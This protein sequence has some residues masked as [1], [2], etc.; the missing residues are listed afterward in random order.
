MTHSRAQMLLWPS[1]HAE[2][3]HTRG[4]TLCWPRLAVESAENRLWGFT[5]PEQISGVFQTIISIFIDWFIFLW[6]V[7]HLNLCGLTSAECGWRSTAQ[8]QWDVSHQ[9]VMDS[10]MLLIRDYQKQRKIT[11]P[12]FQLWAAPGKRQW[13]FTLTDLLT[14]SSLPWYCSICFFS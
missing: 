11:R 4:P 5:R 1:H 8:T 12:E 13:I 3:T 9:R 14:G 2:V 7:N 10:R 6:V